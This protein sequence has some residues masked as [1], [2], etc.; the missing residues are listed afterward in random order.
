MILSLK[1]ILIRNKKE[2]MN[3]LRNMIRELANDFEIMGNGLRNSLFYSIIKKFDG[4][5]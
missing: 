3:N 4:K 2:N 1:T 5:M